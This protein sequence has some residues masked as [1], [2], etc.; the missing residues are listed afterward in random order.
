[1]KGKFLLFGIFFIL[2][3]ITII[4]VGYA[5]YNTQL[6]IS[7]EAVVDPAQ[8][9]EITNISVDS[10][11]SGGF[12]TYVANFS[13]DDSKIYATLPNQSSKITFNITVT[14]NSSDIYRI[15]SIEELFSDNPNIKY[16]I[17]DQDILYFNPN[18]STDIQITLYYDSS[19]TSNTSIGLGLKYN[20]VIVN[21]DPIEY[22]VFS[23]TQYIQTNLS[24]TGDYIFESEV[25]QT[26]YTNND[27]GWIFSARTTAAYTL[28]VFI[29]KTGV[30]KG[31]GGTT[32]PKY[33]YKAINNWI[34]DILL[35]I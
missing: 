4:S 18:S 23:G 27:G 6:M 2:I 34:L 20:F 14:N 13:K 29:G 31:Y 15:E 3:S 1:M 30:Y 35:V 32:S 21:Y 28:G 11:V 12:E 33:P 25:Y 16:E 24:N 8:I 5:S 7:G 22:V 17:I 9:I 19:I 26:E 10:S